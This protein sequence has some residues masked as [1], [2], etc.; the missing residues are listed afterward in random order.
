MGLADKHE[1]K[2]NVLKLFE[3]AVEDYL[4]KDFFIIAP[5]LKN[6]FTSPVFLVI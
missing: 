2:Q 3:K 4:C 1:E 6:Y 5:F